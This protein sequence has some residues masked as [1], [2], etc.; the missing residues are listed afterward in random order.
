MERDGWKARQESAAGNAS[1]NI[2]NVR[3]CETQLLNRDVQDGT[4]R[5]SFLVMAEL[6]C[7]YMARYAVME[8]V[9]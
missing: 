6:I 1:A 4:F 5:T 8:Q 9:Q 3:Q 2:S 7:S